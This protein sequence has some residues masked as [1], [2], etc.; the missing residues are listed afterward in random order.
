MLLTIGVLYAQEVKTFIAVDGMIIAI[1]MRQILSLLIVVSLLTLS[2]TRRETKWMPCPVSDEADLIRVKLDSVV[3]DTVYNS[4][5]GYSGVFDEKIYYY[6]KYFGFLYLFD[7]NGKDPSRQIGMG[8][9][10][11]ESVIKKA[12]SCCF[13][14]DDNVLVLTGAT[15]DFQSFDLNSR[16][17]EYIM[18]PFTPDQEGNENNFFNYSYSPFNLTTACK[19]NTLYVNLDSQH[20]N[21][22]YFQDT[23]GFL[24][25]ALHLGVVNLKDKTA[26]T[27]V[28]GYP[29]VYSED[30]YKYASVSLLNFCV[31]PDL[32]FLVG[33]EADSTLYYCNSEGRPVRAFG[34]AGK[35]MDMDYIKVR[36]F[37]ESKAYVENRETKGYY[38][39]ISYFENGI[40]FRAYRKGKSSETDGLQIYR[41]DNLIA[42]V[43]VPKGLYVT[44]KIGD[45]YYSQIFIDPYTGE[46]T[47]FRVLL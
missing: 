15:L 18:L 35:D 47:V 8:N 22:N 19:K 9:G 12:K 23:G 5:E 14:S 38:G 25:K 29:T 39:N 42:D 6:D 7:L 26:K 16:K 17:S 31:L 41:D 37:E 4:Y 24:K 40:V 33:F 32:S 45:L 28:R 13:S 34:R 21:L 2:C 1:R 27:I 30:P 46:M 36:S 11:F 3:L 10:P 20:P 44:G 43:D